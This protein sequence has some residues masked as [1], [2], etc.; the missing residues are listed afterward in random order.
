MKDVYEIEGEGT[1]IFEV[2]DFL[3]KTKNDG[4]LY[5]C[6]DVRQNYKSSLWGKPKHNHLVI[7]KRIK[8][9]V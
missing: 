7:F 1:P 5:V 3:D 9:G 6:T 8:M 4:G 2:G